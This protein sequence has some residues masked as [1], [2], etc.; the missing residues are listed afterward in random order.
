MKKSLIALAIM[1]I[2]FYAL[3]LFLAN[4]DILLFWELLQENHYDIL[5]WLYVSIQNIISGL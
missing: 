5:A 2:I 3:V 1:L 4:G